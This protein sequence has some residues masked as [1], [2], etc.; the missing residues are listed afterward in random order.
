MRRRRSSV[1]RGFDGLAVCRGRRV[2]TVV[3]VNVGGS[4]VGSR[5][6]GSL[7]ARVHVNGNDREGGGVADGDGG[8]DGGQGLYRGGRVL[9][10]FLRV[11]TLGLMR[12]VLMSGMLRLVT[13]GL[14]RGARKRIA[15]RL[16]GTR[17]SGSAVLRGFLEVFLRGV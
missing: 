17:V 12:L 16:A 1:V 11:N 8:R 3:G 9:G 7:V 15:F 10:S 13:S 2:V 5:R 14:T 4:L 6:A